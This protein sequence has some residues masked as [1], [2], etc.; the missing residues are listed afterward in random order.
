MRFGA[1]RAPLQ[2]IGRRSAW[3]WKGCGGSGRAAATRRETLLLSP[4]GAHREHR[5][6]GAGCRRVRSARSRRTGADT[7]ILQRM[8]PLRR[9]APRHHS[10]LRRFP[11]RNAILGRQS[12]AEE[13]EYLAHESVDSARE[14]RSGLRPC[15]SERHFAGSDTR[16]APRR[17]QTPYRLPAPSR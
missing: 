8:Y 14:A 2:R 17:T 5:G 16:P 3:R 15:R 11:H 4:S 1:R 12:T 9:A 13:R 7:R 10:P 6:A